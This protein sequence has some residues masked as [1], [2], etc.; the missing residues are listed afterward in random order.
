MPAVLARLLALSGLDPLPRGR[1]LPALVVARFRSDVSQE[2]ARALRERNGGDMKDVRT[3]RRGLVVIAL[4]AIAGAAHA[5][6]KDEKLCADLADFRTSVTNLQQMGPQSTVGD[7][8]QTESKLSATEKRIT[9]EAKRDKHAR[10]LHAAQ[11]DLLP[12]GAVRN[13][14]AGAPRPSSSRASSAGRQACAPRCA[15]GAPSRSVA[16]RN[17][18]ASEI[19]AM[20][21]KMRLTPMNVP[22]SHTLMFGIWLMVR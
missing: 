2:C 16:L 5:K 14:G 8:R 12:G 17:P 13:C 4:A 3:T 22:M 6:S 19:R 1:L 15:G 11:P 20:P 21:A 9:K 18:R 7:L 10:D